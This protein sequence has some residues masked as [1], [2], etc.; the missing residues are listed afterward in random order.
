MSVHRVLS[1]TIISCAETMA[2]KGTPKSKKPAA[3]KSPAA[4][5]KSPA[6]FLAN[7]AVNM[8]KQESVVAGG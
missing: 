5:S 7:S 4:A 8:A 3:K 6:K 2:K 1:G